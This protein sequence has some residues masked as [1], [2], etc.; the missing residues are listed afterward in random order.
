MLGLGAVVLAHTVMVSVM[1]MTPIH[2][3]DGRASLAIIGFV[4][5]VHVAG[6]Y[7][8]SPVMGWLADRL[9]RVVMISAGGGMLLAAVALAGTAPEGHSAGL[10]AGLFL[11]GLGWS[12]C[13]VAGS[14]L[15]SESVALDERPVVQGTSDLLMGLAAAGGGAA[16]GFVVSNLGYGV[17]NTG[18]AGIVVALL[19]GAGWTG[20]RHPAAA[21]PSAEPVDAA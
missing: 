2:M 12:A 16:A 7:A 15:L 5:S 21:S 3:D 10:T 1:V 17:L 19:V 20:S 8:F 13:L 14:T 6:M 11:L 18:A 9:G 4:I